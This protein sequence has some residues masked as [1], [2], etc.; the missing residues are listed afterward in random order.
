MSEIDAINIKLDEH[1]KSTGEQFEEV[2]QELADGEIKMD[3]LQ[4]SIDANSESVQ[5]IEENTEAMVK[6]WKDIQGAV[7]VWTVMQRIGL[8]IVKWPIIGA[9]LVAIWKWLSQDLV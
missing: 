6:A 2:R 4:A 1:I 5:Q 7:S 3:K 8:W 9:G